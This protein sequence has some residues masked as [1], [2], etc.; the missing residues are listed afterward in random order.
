MIILKTISKYKLNFFIIILI[1]FLNYK[2][3]SSKENKIIFK[4]NDTAFT[5]LD[6][7]KRIEYLDFVGTN[8]ID[9]NIIKDDFISANLFYE[10]FKSLKTK[11]GYKQEINKIYE[12]ILNQNIKNNKEHKYE[13]SKNNIL[14]NIKIDYIR[15][16]I[17]ENIFN[18]NEN[19]FNGSQEEIDLLYNIKVKYINF[20][21][22]DF[23]KINN[24]INNLN[25]FNIE[26]I[27]KFLNDNNIEFFTK[28]KE[29]NNINDIDKRIKDNIL[30]NKK[31]FII[32]NKNLVSL[33][34]I[35]K[36]FET[37]EGIVVNL[38][39]VR[40]KNELKSEF[41]NCAN[42]SK[43]ENK[44]I[45]KKEYEMKDLNNNLKQN[46]VNINDFVKYINNDENVYIVLCNIQF[47][48]EIFNNVNF[49]KL[50]NL[51]INEIENKFINEYS[52]IY[53]LVQF[54]E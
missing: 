36:N 17:L 12:N 8:N 18:S 11:E 48:K 35:E 22:N 47:N 2:Y 39:S 51:N 34:F 52:K 30:S 7:E 10:Y 24:E 15:K 31:F 54:D 5:S 25:D 50:V 19:N 28:E 43:D 1:I 13:I 14:L 42:L 38:Y 40:S 49:N 26:I 45:L 53:N 33:I 46:L 41:L 44:N 20:K 3:I 32:E 29:I 4:I 27:K 6:L 16:I 23:N 21:V 9:R 37:F